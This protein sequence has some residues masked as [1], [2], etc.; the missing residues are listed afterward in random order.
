[1]KIDSTAK[2]L[3]W[4]NLIGETYVTEPI[5]GSCSDWQQLFSS[6]RR[7]GNITPLYFFRYFQIRLTP[8]HLLLY[9]HISFIVCFVD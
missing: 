4:E 1:M 9:H 6:K 8:I 7:T 3:L 2:K 5:K